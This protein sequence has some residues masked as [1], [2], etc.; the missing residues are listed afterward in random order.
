MRRASTA[1]FSASC[2]VAGASDGWF[3]GRQSPRRG[4]R[5]NSARIVDQAR[6]ERDAG[7]R[8]CGWSPDSA[9]Q[10]PLHLR[11]Q[12]SLFDFDQGLKFAQLMGVAQGRST[13]GIV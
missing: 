10:Q 5:H 7:D 3:R 6:L 1:M 8:V 4:W 11:A 2:V 9:A 13:P 12:S